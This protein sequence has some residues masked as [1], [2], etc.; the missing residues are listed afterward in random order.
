MSACYDEGTLQAYADGELDAARARE[1]MA[2]LRAC[3]ACA[4]TVADATANFALLSSALDAND[5]LSVPT[6]RLRSR[7]NAAIAELQ[8][9]QLA[10]PTRS[11]SFVERLRAFAS[12]LAFVP[13][14]ATAFASL[15]VAA[16]L[17]ATLF[18]L[19][20]PQPRTTIDQQNGATEI[21]KVNPTTSA[22]ASATGQGAADKASAGNDAN[23]S[24]S[25]GNKP[26]IDSSAPPRVV[27]APGGS[28]AFTNVVYKPATGTRDVTSAN[29]AATS[30]VA[31]LPVEKPYAGA[32]ASLKSSIDQQG[33]RLMT[34]AL[35]AEYERNLAVV[36]RAIAASR[37]AARRDPSDKDAQEFLRSAYQDKLELLRAVADQTQIA[38]IAR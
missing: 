3:A 2:H 8:P 4:A 30:E 16:V 28:S 5:A 12:S 15:A 32:V 14:Q 22:G 7:I 11:A 23:K 9:T 31:L 36:D 38:S 24:N 34:P 25:G 20:R 33:A 29:A 35:R 21:A 17:L 26:V 27:R 6:E 37:V 18:Y 10:P 13:R 19:S 1:L